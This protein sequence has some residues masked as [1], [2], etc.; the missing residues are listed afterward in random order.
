MPTVLDLTPDERR[1]YIQSA[2]RHF[3]TLDQ[4][5]EDQVTRARLI[6]RARHSAADLK[7]RF[8]VRRVVLFGSLAHSGWFAADSDVDVAVEGLR[9]TDYWDAWRLLE[10]TIR[11]REVDLIEIELASESLRRSIE[12]HGVEL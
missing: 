4:P 7:T 1:R 6:E 9:P 11:E 12:R 3:A 2:R 8:G 10:D 5:A